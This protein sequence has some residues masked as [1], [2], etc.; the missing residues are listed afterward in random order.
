MNRLQFESL[1]NKVKLQ[2]R[3]ITRLEIQHELLTTRIERLNATIESLR[4][5]LTK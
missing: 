5:F 3:E 4:Q 1:A 2:E